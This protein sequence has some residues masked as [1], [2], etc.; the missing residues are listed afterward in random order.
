[1][2]TGFWA[3]AAPGGT[4]RGPCLGTAGF[5]I[6]TGLAY[7]FAPILGIRLVGCFR[8]DLTGLEMDDAGLSPPS[9]EKEVADGGFSVPTS[10][11][12]NFEVLPPLEDEGATPWAA[13]A[14]LAVVGRPKE[15]TLNPWRLALALLIIGPCTRGS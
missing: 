5:E 13:D 8:L 6:A 4:G 3:A 9:L 10:G 15:G 1:M 12:G 7:G 14:E 11:Y 2:T